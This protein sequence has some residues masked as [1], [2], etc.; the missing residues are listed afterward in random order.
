MEASTKPQ[1]QFGEEPDGTVRAL[2]DRI[3][4]E[5]LTV[6]DERAAQLVRE[7]AQAGTPGASTVRDAIV[8]G[9][10][11]LDR[12]ST[13]AEVDLVKNEL[14]SQLGDL[15]AELEET[16]ETRAVQ[17]AEMLTIAF[18]AERNDSVQAQIREIVS[19]QATHQREALH[20]TLTAE[21]GSNP[22]IA[23]Q[24]RIGKAMLAA[25]ERNRA[26]VERLRESHSKE[27]RALLGQIGEVRKELAQVLE[28]D[29][30]D[31]RV[32]AEAER[33]TAKGRTFEEMTNGFLEEIAG[34]H[35][36]A[37]RHTGEVSNE[38]G[39][40]KGDTV[41]EIGAA[42][43]PALA[44]I[45]FEA[46]N[47]KLS[48]N[49]AWTELGACIRERDAA[50]A[51]LVVAGDDKVPSGLEEMTEYQGNKMIAV[52]DREDPDPLALRLVYRYVR[53]RVLAASA[54]GLEVDASG[55]RDA[56]EEACAS[57]KRVN[58]IRKSL[59]GVTNS[60][61]AARE[62]LDAMVGDVEDC[63]TRIES[64]VAAAADEP[65]A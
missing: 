46:K 39:A 40:K 16:L 23:V 31:V 13:G 22:L 41:V 11:V 34:A 21:D 43:G 28:R 12:E 58:R 19:S 17:M 63:L 59:T 38:S 62:E 45:V 26:E 5:G 51:V 3:V 7:R 47:K 18:G 8:I 27:T 36:D 49:D 29:D 48:K 44:T 55:V 54:A 42:V 25:E 14:R 65:A 9:A 15:G 50:Y 20:K 37:A 61:D 4:I 30:A 1:L 60:A 10:R 33:G 6:D 32:A 24:E 35:S 53:A 64:L 2:G 57:L 52:L 56:A